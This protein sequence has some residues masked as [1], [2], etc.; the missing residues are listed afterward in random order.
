MLNILPILLL[1]SS[2]L[3]LFSQQVENR[4]VM[5]AQDTCVRSTPTPIVKKS[6]F[7]N[8][9]FVLKKTNNR[10][11]IISEGIETVKLNN[12]DRLTITNSGCEFLTLN[13]RFETNRRSKNSQD[14]K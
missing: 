6:V 9:S 1:C 14:P 13:F 7:P 2:L 3:A 4:E 5:I 8:T 11:L 12:G 10:G